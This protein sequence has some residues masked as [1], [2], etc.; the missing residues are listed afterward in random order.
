MK[1][2]KS[3]K[4]FILFYLAYLIFFINYA[5]SANLSILGL[6]KLTKSDLNAITS[7]DIEKD[8]FDNNEINQI[9]ND[10]YSSDLIYNLQYELI[11]NTHVMQIYESKIIENIFING[12]IKIKDNIILENISSTTNFFLNKNNISNDINK[13]KNIYSSI[14]YNE[15]KINVQIENY[16][17]DRVNLIFQVNEGKQSEL[18]NI[19]FLGNKTYPDSFLNSLINSK[20]NNFY[21]IFS[22][23]SNF[24]ESIFNFDV[25]KL[26]DFYKQKGFFEI[27]ITYALSDFKQSKY[28]LIFYINEGS[29]YKIKNLFYE[30]NDTNNFI[31]DN[32]D[33]KFQ[34]KI[35][36]NDFYFDKDLIIDHLENLN[37]Q[38]SDTGSNTSVFSFKYNIL[39][40]NQIDLIFY[41]ENL[42]PKYINKISISG[43]AITKDKTIRNKLNFEPGDLYSSNTLIS[44][45]KNLNQLRYINSIDIYENVI[46]DQKI[47]IDIK[48]DENIKTG[49]FLVGGSISGDVGFGLGLSLKDYNLFGTGNEIDSSFNLNSEQALFT[50]NYTTSPFANPSISNTY[51]AFNEE[52]DFISSFGYKTKILGFG[53]NANFQ[54]N[55]KLA[56]SSGIIYE[57]TEGYAAINNN[58]FITDNIGQFQDFSIQFSLTRNN[59]NDFLYP[60]EGS[61]NR[62]NIEY[63]P[64]ILSDDPFYKIIYN[65]DLYFKRKNKNSFFFFDNNLGIAKSLNGKLKTKNSFSLGG[66][67]F[68]GFDY[69]GVG[70]YSE[71]IYL[72]GNNYFTST[73]G[74][75]SSFLFDE[76]DNINLKV[77]YSTGSIWNSDYVSDDD[78]RIRS[79]AGISFDVLTVIGPLS[80]SYA[81]P[82]DSTSNDKKKSFNFSIGSSF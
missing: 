20:A 28:S 76:K 78:I 53:Y 70:P 45:K 33:D 21:N 9:L 63:S 41:Q 42:S 43:N 25:N 77:F 22:S 40:D 46:S 69:R 72:G 12:N 79:S 23:G 74:Y 3:I 1:N 49:T 44:S 55:E 10:F 81:V 65:N 27:E 18:I 66:L 60:T 26:I 51:S 24:G 62:V 4:I 71:N 29:R 39:N 37:T 36:K 7:I 30:S 68:K 32:L 11:N 82:I 13:I 59:T 75:G 19:E 34:K 61:Y 67:N 50:I 31:V 15:S 47:D 17:K 54:L 35:D 16:S 6:E 57:D 64:K 56:L 73:V 52:N 80:F 38:L 5:Y 14:G 2:M 48:I 58:S 8:Y